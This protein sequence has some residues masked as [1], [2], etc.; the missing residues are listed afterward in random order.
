MDNGSSLVNIGDLAK[1]ATVLIEKI[2]EAIGGIFKP[3]QIRRVAE[4]EAQAEKIRA[5]TQI[6]ITE[7][8]KRAIARF[9]AEEAKK[10]NNIEDITKKALSEIK[11]DARPEDIE[12]DWI[13]H[14]FDRCR[15]ISNE[16]MKILW[17]KVLAGQANSP[18]TYS[19][20]TIDIL[21]NLERADAKTFSKLCGFCI[22][23]GGY[24]PLVY[25]LGQKIYS[26]HGITFDVVSHLESLGLIHFGTF[27]SY[28]RKGLGQKGF[29]KYFDH[30]LWIEFQNPE[31]NEMKIG[32]I[33]LTKAGQQLAPLSGAVPVDGFTD[34]VEEI[35]KGFGYKT[36]PE[37]P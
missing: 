34:Y 9:F 14:F 3:Y 16:E 27:A 15:L 35:W 10:Q 21:I 32:T 2:S 36:K 7:L 26:D 18:G 24:Y 1:P 37:E 8:Q 6:E 30:D 28:V 19:K 12:D 17:A 4:A 5:F 23:I 25:D 33:I 31:N 11:E 13:T 22:E 20:K 29:V